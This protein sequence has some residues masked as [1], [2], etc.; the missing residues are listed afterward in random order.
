MVNL[1]NLFGNKAITY[2]CVTF[3]GGNLIDANPTEPIFIGNRSGNSSDYLEGTPEQVM[4]SLE[5]ICQKHGGTKIF[6]GKDRFG[7]EARIV[8]GY[9]IGSI[10]VFNYV[11]S[12]HPRKE[13]VVTSPA[14]KSNGPLI[15]DIWRCDVHEA[16][17]Y[18]KF[19][20]EVRCR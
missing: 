15:G 5:T 7:T 11:D 14:G 12:F 1:R 4:K 13:I 9:M 18:H 10:T 16:V 20:K 2:E 17:G 19:D 3:I 6:E 8:T